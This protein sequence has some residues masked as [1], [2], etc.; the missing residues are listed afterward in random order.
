MLRPTPEVVTE[1]QDAFDALP[2]DPSGLLAGF[3]AHQLA[4]IAEYLSRATDFSYR[5]GALLRAQLLADGGRNRSATSI[6][7]KETT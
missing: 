4:A 3:D 2:V 7:D 1:V 5:R 6:V